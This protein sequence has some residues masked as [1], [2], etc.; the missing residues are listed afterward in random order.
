MYMYVPLH[1]YSVCTTMII[2]FHVMLNIVEVLTCFM[3]F[4]AKRNVQLMHSS[5]FNIILGGR[6]HVI[7]ICYCPVSEDIIL[8]LLY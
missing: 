6:L 7:C 1:M 3:K 5:T 8:Y 4:L 2:I